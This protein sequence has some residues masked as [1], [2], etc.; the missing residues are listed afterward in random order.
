MI[1]KHEANQTDRIKQGRESGELTK[2]EARRLKAEQKLIDRTQNRAE[3]D[4]SVSA[5]ERSRI[6][7]MQDRAGKDIQRQKHDAASAPATGK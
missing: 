7:H 1:D 6:R 5:K 4:G 3:A 2:R